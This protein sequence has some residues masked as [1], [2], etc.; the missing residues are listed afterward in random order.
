MG[1]SHHHEKT[2]KLGRDCSTGVN[3]CLVLLVVIRLVLGSLAKTVVWGGVRRF[4]SVAA[5]P[6]D[7]ENRR[8]SATG[9]VWSRDK[10]A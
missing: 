7:K 10:G 4:H 3:P 1:A 6:A 2:L 5:Q 8:Y 9:I